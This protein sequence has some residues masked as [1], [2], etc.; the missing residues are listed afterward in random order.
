MYI[1]PLP[2]FH[3]GQRTSQLQPYSGVFFQLVKNRLSALD[4]AITE[5][6]GFFFLRTKYISPLVSVACRYPKLWRANLCTCIHEWSRSGKYMEHSAGKLTPWWFL[7][8]RHEHR[9]GIVSAL[10]QNPHRTRDANASKW[11]ILLLRMGVF[12][13]DASN[14]KGIDCKKACF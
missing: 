9:N 4:E 8:A 5:E 12:T 1:F 7:W 13:L 3:F 2:T 11:W 10:W 14:I 6:N